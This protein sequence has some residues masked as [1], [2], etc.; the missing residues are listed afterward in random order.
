[1]LGIFPKFNSSSSSNIIPAALVTT[2]GTIGSSQANGSINVVD[3]GKNLIGEDLAR[4]LAASDI[5]LQAKDSP[6]NILSENIDPN[7]VSKLA[8]S[9][10]KLIRQ[11]KPEHIVVSHGT[12][13]MNEVV[14]L[15]SRDTR[16]PLDLYADK[17]KNAGLN[18]LISD[19]QDTIHQNKVSIVFTGANTTETEEKEKNMSTAF[20]AVRQSPRLE[21]GLET[22]YDAKSKLLPGIYIAFHDRL[23][24]AET[25][26]KDVFNPEIGMR[27]AD[28]ESPSYR[29]RLADL[30]ATDRELIS[31]LNDGTIYLD[32]EKI[33]TRFAAK[34]Q[35]ATVLEYEVN[36]IRENHDDFLQKID[37][38]PN[39]KAI[40]LVLYHSG[41]ANTNSDS[42]ASVLKMIKDI[43]AKRPD[44]AIY[45]VNE[46]PGEPVSLSE[47]SYAGASDLKKAG[48]IPLGTMHRSIALAK[49]QM[50]I[51]VDEF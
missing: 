37:Q 12:D 9:L 10:I 4:K 22:N 35:S 8:E 17:A 11:A 28:R 42:E 32:S 13:S 50:G 27:Y 38:S 49:L 3:G 5:R 7:Y 14:N 1:M 43:K 51:P 36:K 31:Q 2:G 19:L 40:L 15:L 29:K 33:K 25:A 48:L 16:F 44:I 26:T 46:N 34:E 47:T 41:T 21:E 20:L 23:I 24:R 30:E 18:S 6:Y 39:L 45:A